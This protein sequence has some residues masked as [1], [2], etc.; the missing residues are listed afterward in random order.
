MGMMSRT[1]KALRQAGHEVRFLKGKVTLMSCEKDG[2]LVAVP[3]GTKET[4][5]RCDPKK[6]VPSV[7][8]D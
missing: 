3:V 6:E 5:P 4:P 1:R 8:Q 7:P 2:C